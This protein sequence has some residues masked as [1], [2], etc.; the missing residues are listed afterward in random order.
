MKSF[1]PTDFSFSDGVQT[2]S[3]AN[4]NT[5]P[6]FI[7]DVFQFTTDASGAIKGWN[8]QI[9][10]DVF[11]EL[12]QTQNSGTQDDQGLSGPGYGFN[13]DNPGNFSPATVAATPLPAALPLFAGGLGLI[14]MIGLRKKRK[15]VATA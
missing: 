4:S 6:S 8:I 2:I 10:N 1:T 7:F 11:A 12:I 5:D 15:A 9:W 14:G 13:N 3:Y